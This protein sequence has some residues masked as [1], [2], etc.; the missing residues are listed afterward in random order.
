[1][2]DERSAVQCVVMILQRKAVG[3]TASDMTPSSS[4]SSYES[5]LLLLLYSFYVCNKKLNFLSFY[6]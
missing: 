2:S 4:S 3:S 1:M 5:I 6:V